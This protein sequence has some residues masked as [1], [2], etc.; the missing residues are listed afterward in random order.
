LRLSMTCVVASA[1]LSPKLSFAE[2]HCCNST[3]HCEA[4]F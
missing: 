3:S 1:G 4:M 2:Y